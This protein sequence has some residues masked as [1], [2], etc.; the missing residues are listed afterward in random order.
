VEVLL[1]EGVLQRLVEVT[2]QL[3]I[4]CTQ[5]KGPL[6]VPAMSMDLANGK[7]SF[8]SDPP[9]DKRPL[10]VSS[11]SMAQLDM[12]VVLKCEFQRSIVYS[13]PRTAGCFGRL[14]WTTIKSRK[15]SCWLHVAAEHSI[16]GYEVA[17][18]RTCGSQQ[19]SQV[20]I[21]MGC[22]PDSRLVY[23]LAFLLQNAC[24]TYFSLLQRCVFVPLGG[25]ST[26]LGHLLQ[27]QALSAAASPG[28]DAV[29]TALEPAVTKLHWSTGLCIARCGKQTWHQAIVINSGTA[30]KACKRGWPAFAGQPHRTVCQQLRE[31]AAAVGAVDRADNAP[32]HATVTS[33]CYMCTLCFQGGKGGGCYPQ[34]ARSAAPP[35]HTFSC[36]CGGL[37]P[38]CPRGHPSHLHHLSAVEV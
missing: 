18:C 4:S 12:L 36:C 38:G 31:Q 6:Q 34:L 21:A 22:I 27:Q 9:K 33:V 20:S 11:R 24:S 14:L 1:G 5:D 2:T 13:L 16:Q 7:L 30:M 10:V 37:Q 26:L 35:G 28:E 8:P 32:L 23:A 19:H 3:V 29:V 25:H 15:C 17:A